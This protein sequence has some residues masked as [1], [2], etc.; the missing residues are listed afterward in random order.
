MK[1]SFIGVISFFIFTQSALANDCKEQIRSYLQPMV[2]KM[3][4]EA[5]ERN[6]SSLEQKGRIDHTGTDSWAASKDYKGTA[7]LM[8]YPKKMK[9]TAFD[10]KWNSDLYHVDV[11][12][13]FWHTEAERKEMIKQGN[14]T[15]ACGNPVA[16][17]VNAQCE[18][19]SVKKNTM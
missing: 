16:V 18:V 14:I 13:R 19:I 6:F 7:P 11:C 1:I 15:G 8:L 9:K 2:L 3:T 17:H 5:A 4:L 12:Y 10:K